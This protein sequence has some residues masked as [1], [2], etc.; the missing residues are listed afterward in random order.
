MDYGQFIRTYITAQTYG[1]GIFKEK[2]LE[3]YDAIVA[4]YKKGYQENVETI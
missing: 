1:D 4:T 3:E 2:V